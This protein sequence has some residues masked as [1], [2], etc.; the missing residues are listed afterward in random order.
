LVVWDEARTMLRSIMP[1]APPVDGQQLLVTYSTGSR[2]GNSVYVTFRAWDR[3]SMRPVDACLLLNGR[4]YQMS[5]GY[6]VVALPESDL[7]EAE[8]KAEY[9]GMR[10]WVKMP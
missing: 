6:V 2:V 9:P 10:P 1:V 7:N 5:D 8:M 3:A 4:W